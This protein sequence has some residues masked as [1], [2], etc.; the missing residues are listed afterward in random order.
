MK[1]LLIRT[2]G[3]LLSTNAVHTYVFAGAT[4]G[5]WYGLSGFSR[6]LANTVVSALFLGLVIY[7]RTK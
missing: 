3:A 5:L 1:E 7:A 4:A 2:V 6:P